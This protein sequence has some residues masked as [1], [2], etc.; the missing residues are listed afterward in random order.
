MN[1]VL[2]LFI[3]RKIINKV[4][5]SSGWWAHKSA[6]LLDSFL[7]HPAWSLNI[8]FWPCGAFFVLLVCSIFSAVLTGFISN[9][10][11]HPC[12]FQRR[13]VL[14][15]GVAACWWAANSGGVAFACDP[16]LC[17]VFS[18]VF[19]HLVALARSCPAAKWR[20]LCFPWATTGQ[21]TCENLP[22][23][24]IYM[25]SSTKSEGGTCLHLT[26]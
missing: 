21:Y 18:N 10:F 17:C 9:M 3:W 24:I 22:K 1:T 8:F 14:S 26:A 13:E 12:H 4:F 23:W 7:I 25:I 6:A 16:R 20:S 11:S 2:C 5:S 19:F 15:S